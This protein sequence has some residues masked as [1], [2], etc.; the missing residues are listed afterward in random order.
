MLKSFKELIVWQKAYQ[1]CLEIYR[2]SKEFPN[3]EKYGLS[4]QMR[5]AALSIPSNIAEGYGRRTI[6]DYVRCLYIAYGSTCE[7]ETQILLAKDLD[8]LESD[9]ESLILERINEVERML[10]ALIKSLEIKNNP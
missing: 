9:D 7:L 1:L 6:P 3:D 8:Y 2:I 5:R 4:S 10:M